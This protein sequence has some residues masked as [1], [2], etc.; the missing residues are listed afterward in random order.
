M[1]VVPGAERL[2]ERRIVRQVGHDAQLDLAV[3]GGEQALVSVADHEALP[4][5]PS[6]LGP[7]RDV[8]QVGVGGGEPAGGGDHL[9]VGRVDAAV[10]AR[11]RDER[12]DD[13]LEPG[14]VPVPQ[15]VRQH[16]VLGLREQAGQ[17]LRV[18]R[19]PG[20]DPLG[21]GQ[22]QLVEEHL[23]QLLGRAQVE[24]PAHH[25]VGGLLGR[26]HLAA[27]ARRHRREVI[28]VGGDPGPLHPGQDADQR[29]L[30][31]V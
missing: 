28:G 21:L 19:V 5:P 6:L 16:G 14:H 20:L 12:V 9:V 17:R 2:L 27:Q 23:L 1:E 25:R 31:L 10:L 13:A 22:A 18:G 8:L 26:L 24:L 3:V 15:Q 4:D 30:H 29:Q 11:H 7:D